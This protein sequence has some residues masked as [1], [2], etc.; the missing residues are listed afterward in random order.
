[1]QERTIPGG[2]ELMTLFGSMDERFEHEKRVF[3]AAVRESLAGSG[4]VSRRAIIF[5]IIGEME[6]I[7]DP[8]R[9]DVLRSCLEILVSIDFE[10]DAL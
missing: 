2:Q 1:M 6:T 9:L 5:C 7:T 4:E 3:C 8:L 10:P